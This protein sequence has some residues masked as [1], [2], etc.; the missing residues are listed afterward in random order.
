MIMTTILSCEIIGL[1]LIKDKLR[2]T[3]PPTHTTEKSHLL[4]H[5]QHTGCLYTIYLFHFFTFIFAFIFMF[6][7]LL[8]YLYIYYLV[9]ITLLFS[10]VY[11]HVPCNP[12]HFP[13]WVT[14]PR[15]R[16][17]YARHVNVQVFLHLL[18]I[19]ISFS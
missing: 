16:H 19:T 6:V 7:H 14:K 2:P 10:F 15:Y 18:A 12:T 3:P 8:I 4:R 11:L 13:K 1:R 17:R 9:I 5:T